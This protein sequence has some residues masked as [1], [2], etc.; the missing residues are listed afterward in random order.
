MRFRR[1]W[2]VYRKE[3]LETLRDRRTLIAML[4][5]PLALYPILMLVVMQALQI[6]KSRRA[7]DTY[8]VAVPDDTHRRWL[9]AVLAADVAPG[10]ARRSKASTSNHSAPASNS[11]LLDAPS[12]RAAEDARADEAGED[13]GEAHDAD[14]NGNAE[15]GLLQPQ[16]AVQF[17]IFVTDE[18]LSDVVGRGSAQAALRTDPPVPAHSLGDETNREVQLTYDASEYRSEVAFRSLARLMARQTERAIVARLERLGRGSDLLAPLELREVSV[19][20]PSKLGGSLLGQV[21]PF[22]LVIMTITG[23]IHPAIDLTAGERER[24]TLET[25]MVAPV[26][27]GQVVAGKF[28]V[29]TTIAVLSSTLNLLSMG[30]TIRFG[31]IGDVMT[32]TLPGAGAIAIPLSVFPIVLAAMIPF[33]VL[34]SGVMVAACSFARTF[35]EAQTYMTPVMIAALMPAMITSYMPS[36]KLTGVVPVV[37]VANV[38]VLLRE[39]FL[40][41]FDVPAI[42]IAVGSTCLYAAAAVMAATQLYGQEAVLFADVGSYK[43]LLQRRFIRPQPAP[44]PTAALLLTAVVFPLSFYWQLSVSKPDMSAARLQ[45]MTI[46]LMLACF[47]APVLLLTW[48]AKFD[49]RRTLSLRGTSPMAWVG[50]VLLAAASPVLAHRVGQAIMQAFAPPPEVAQAL[51]DVQEKMLSMPLAMVLLTFAVLPAVCEELLFRGFVQSGL[52]RRLGP[53]ALCVTVGILFGLFHT[54]VYRIPTTSLLG[55]LLA[56]VCWRT[57]SIFPGMLI[58]VVNNGA[59][60]LAGKMPA[61]ASALGMD[62]S[63]RSLPL[64][65]AGAALVAGLTL[66]ACSRRRA[67]R[68]AEPAATSTVV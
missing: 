13:D 21:L 23:A 41:H 32:R 1:V 52:A 34:F 28:L 58:H 44:S 46:V 26:P 57:G 48:Y 35:K 18:D 12:T 37:P 61:V 7:R 60:M 19:A 54:D 16:A 20:S 67:E 30:A 56:Y 63:G 42:L 38:V 66:I 4:L 15:P 3:L 8:R 24:G 22:L 14:S 59:A 17:D 45:F 31:G 47:L 10:T 11:T 53:V 2:V 36:I 50:A 27:T 6:E 25:L 43:T 29:V 5:V 9:M 55:V 39:L 51:A 68:M 62:E 40:G 49:L 64:W 65:L 33:A